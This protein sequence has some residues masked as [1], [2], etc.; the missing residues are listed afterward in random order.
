M[1]CCCFMEPDLGTVKVLLAEQ[2]T[3]RF[4][5]VFSSCRAWRSAAMWAACFC[6]LCTMYS[7]SASSWF[8]STSFSCAI[9]PCSKRNSSSCKGAWQTL[10]TRAE[11]RLGF[12]RRPTMTRIRLLL[13][14]CVPARSC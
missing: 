2:H 11:K 12:S 5:S 9:L 3:C 6:S 1:S 10:H 14:R 13:T 4:R 7:C 8:S